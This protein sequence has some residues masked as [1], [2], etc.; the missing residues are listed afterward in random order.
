MKKR[1]KK[2][3]S[4]S[5][6]YRDNDQMQC[7]RKSA[8]LPTFFQFSFYYYVCVKWVVCTSIMYAIVFYVEMM[9]N[10]RWRNITTMYARMRLLTVVIYLLY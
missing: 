1:K 2:S 7:K 6:R 5:S 4:H 9:K 8:M 10:V 3:L